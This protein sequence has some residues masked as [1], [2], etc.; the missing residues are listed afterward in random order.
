MRR[1]FAAAA[2]ALALSAAVAS[3]APLEAYGRLPAIE[4]VEISPDGSAIALIATVNDQRH[5]IVRTLAGQVA[6]SATIGFN[7]VRAVKWADSEHVLIEVSTTAAIEDTTYVSEQFQV[8]SL[9]IRTGEYKQLPSKALDTVL[10]IVAGR[11]QPGFDGKEAVLYTP[12]YVTDKGNMQHKSAHKDLFKI[13]LDSGIARRVQMGDDETYDY[14]AKADGT[15]LAKAGYREDERADKATWTMSLRKGQSWQPVFTTTTAVE[16]PDL[17]GVTP[18]GQSI[19]IDT[20]DGTAKLWRPT[21]VSLTD[22]KLGEFIGPPVS[23]GGVVGDDGVVLGFTRFKGDSYEYEFLEPRLKALWPAY[24]SA[25]KGQQVSLA[26]WTPDFRKLVLYVSG[27]ATPGAYYIADTTTKRVDPL[28]SP[29]PKVTA[30]DVGPVRMIQYK[31]ADG[32]DIEGVLTL[33]PGRAEKGLPLVVL[34]HGGPRAKDD[35]VFDWWA[36]A[37]ASRGYA[38]LQP[39][40]RGS[41]GYGTEFKEAGYGE[42]GAKMQ[43]DLS[44]GV[45]YL[46]KAGIVDTKRVCIFGHSYGGY[47]ALAGVTLQKGVYRCAVSSA[48]V[49]DLAKMMSD[50]I[51]RSG[52][53]NARVRDEK[54]LF[55]VDSASDPKLDQRSPAA[56]AAK[57]DAPILLIHGKDDTTVPFSH[58]Q[59]MANALKSAGKP[60]EFVVLDGEDHWL[61]KGQTRLQMLTAGITF[62]EKNNPPD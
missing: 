19:I 60:Y 51:I 49:S 39:N 2:M 59:K 20:W 30:A 42:W 13:D 24:R 27:A 61:S 7:K 44:D 10:N 29:Y 16:T 34:P 18:D 40:F 25:F 41:T 47:A 43:T 6:A 5:I 14:L 8:V 50:D 33:P 55:G 11:L 23:Q 9:N 56:Q 62:I 3:A 21:P 1:M 52:E 46:A 48:G 36:Q 58:S 15:V 22:G 45:A 54:R 53:R 28:G 32:L 38:V 26:S 57:A 35:A 17:W 37:I 4:S 31:A 12:L